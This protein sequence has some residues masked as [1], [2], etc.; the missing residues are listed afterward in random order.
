MEHPPKIS[1]LAITLNEGDIIANFLDRLDFVD[2]VVIVDSF[3]S[4]NTLEVASQY[5]KVQIYQRKFDDFSNQKNFAI[6]KASNDWVL[7][8]DPDEEI[9]PAVKE[10]ILKTLENPGAVGYYFR[11]QLYFMGKKIKY[12]GFQTDWVI[13]LFH[14][15]HGQYNGNL[16]HETLEIDGKTQR[17]RTR[18]PHHTYKDFSDYVGKLDRYSTLQAQMNFEKNKRASLFHFL[19]RPA[20]RFWHQYLLRLGILDGKEGLIL[21]YINAHSVF[22]RY[23]K[24]WLL[25]RGKQ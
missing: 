10:E 9:T 14:K 8:F 11:R 21:A 22:K 3:S 13:R 1:A 24:L 18:V 19:F 17:L 6:S 15:K 2:E 5:E 20:Y 25:Q 4:D 23:V 12:S 7:F 16:V